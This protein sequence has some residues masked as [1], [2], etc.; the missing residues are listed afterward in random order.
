MSL[1]AR[2]SAKKSGASLVG[3]SNG[4]FCAIFTGM[5]FHRE[6]LA[7]YGACLFIAG[8]L[9]WQWI[10]PRKY[11]PGSSLREPEKACM[12]EPIFLDYAYNYAPAEPHECKPQCIDGRARYLSYSN[13]LAT[14]CGVPPNCFDWGED[15]GVTCKPEAKTT[16]K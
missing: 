12:G 16:V 3:A 8:V 6:H 13:G 2:R 9:A 7:V 11:S 4:C 1:T 10:F 5:S 15:Q 14:Q